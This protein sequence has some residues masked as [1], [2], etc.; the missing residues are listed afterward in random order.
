MLGSIE[1]WKTSYTLF[2]A[3]PHDLKN[4][5]KAVYTSINTYSYEKIKK[6]HQQNGQGTIH[7]FILDTWPCSYW[8]FAT[9]FIIIEYNVTH[10]ESNWDWRR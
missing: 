6:S 9:Q 1:G 8:G 2:F 5:L 4:M 10:F 7:G 3:N